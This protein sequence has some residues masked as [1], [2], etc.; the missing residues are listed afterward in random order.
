[1]RDWSIVL[2]CNVTNQEPF[3]TPGLLYTFQNSIICR[4]SF[5]FLAPCGMRAQLCLTLCDPVECSPPGSSVHGI[6]Q[7]RVLEWVAISFSRGSSP[8]RDRTSISYVSWLAGGFFT[9][10]ATWEVSLLSFKTLV[11]LI[12]FCKAV[13]YL[14]SM[15]HLSEVLVIC[16]II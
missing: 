2:S 6:L 11:K 10:S 9:T 8:P 4:F 5:S 12:N 14:S 15:S 13:S 3:F 16:I 1:M 7:A